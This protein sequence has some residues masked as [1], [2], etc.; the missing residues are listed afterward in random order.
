MNI[1]TSV[2]HDQF[3][4]VEER[5]FGYAQKQG[6]VVVAA[7]GND[8]SDI[9][10]ILADDQEKESPD[11]LDGVVSVSNVEKVG[12]SATGMLEL[13]SSSNY[14][15]SVTLAA[16]GTDILSDIPTGLANAVAAVSSYTAVPV[17]R[18]Y[19]RHSGL[20]HYVAKTEER[21]ALVKLGWKDEGSSFN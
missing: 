19:N 15:A 6:M 13:S 9:D 10:E 11:R 16:P 7:A 3:F 12:D 14:G 8:S 18:L 2:T 5:A 4:E 21:D 20:H 17:Y 1:G